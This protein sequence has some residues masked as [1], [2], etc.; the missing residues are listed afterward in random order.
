VAVASFARKGGEA[1]PT[2]K[3]SLLL[4]WLWLAAAALIAQVLV[5]Q[6]IGRTHGGAQ[7]LPYLVPAAHALLLPFL[8]RNLSLWG[9]RLVLAGLLLNL[10]VMCLNGGLMPVDGSAVAA[11]G[12]HDAAE[13]QLG[14]PIEGTKNIY[15]DSDDIR[16]HAL[17]DVIILPL[18]APL[19]RAASAGDLLILP[20]VVLAFGEVARRGFRNRYR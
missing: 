20:G 14:A 9:I 11:V 1:G 16:L 10:T 3:A 13:L 15:L 2:P 18:P 17:A 4:P 5:I 19:T 12:R 6:G 8:L 7:L